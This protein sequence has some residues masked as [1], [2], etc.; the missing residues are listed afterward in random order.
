MGR[1]GVNG[2]SLPHRDSPAYMYHLPY[3]QVR[4][5]L[6]TLSLPRLPLSNHPLSSIQSSLTCMPYDSP[7]PLPLSYLHWRSLTPALSFLLRKP[8]LWF[9]HYH[10]PITFTGKLVQENLRNQLIQYKMSKYSLPSL[11]LSDANLWIFHWRFSDCMPEVATG[12]NGQ[13]CGYRPVRG[14]RA[15]YHGNSPC[16]VLE[17]VNGFIHG[18]C[19]DSSALSQV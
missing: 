2:L 16:L 1:K 9:F 8:P 4:E 18:I 19:I 17:R 11:L 13:S 5:S 3:F 15:L 6:A 10:F 7:L 14:D 12:L